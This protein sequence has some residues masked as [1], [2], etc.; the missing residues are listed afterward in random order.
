MEWAKGNNETGIA[1]IAA[2]E[3]EVLPPQE[4]AAPRHAAHN[5]G[6]KS[7]TG[8]GLRNKHLCISL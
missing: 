6:P 5:D 1:E 2:A 8:M 4:T 7:Q 3:Q